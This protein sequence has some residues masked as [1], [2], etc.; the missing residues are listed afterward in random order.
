MA[1][2]MGA[3]TAA[4][5]RLPLSAIVLATVLTIHAGTADEP[6]IIV[7]VVVAYIVTLA[8]SKR[9]AAAPDADETAASADSGE[10]RTV[11]TA[12]AGQR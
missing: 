2:G 11:A 6:L 12:A 3:A 1:V 7:G 10:P 9:S 4:V 8:L 5:L